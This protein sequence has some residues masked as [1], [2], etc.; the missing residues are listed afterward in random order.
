MTLFNYLS[1]HPVWALVYILVLW[2]PLVMLIATYFSTR[3]EERLALAA[4]EAAKKKPFTVED[5]TSG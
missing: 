4:I 1:A 3:K 5:R 2:L